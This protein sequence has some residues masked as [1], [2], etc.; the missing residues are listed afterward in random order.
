I[1]ARSVV[2]LLG[3]EQRI[4]PA[5]VVLAGEIG[6]VAGRNRL[7]IIA[8]QIRL[9]PGTAGGGQCLTGTA[10]GGVSIG[11]SGEAGAGRRRLLGEEGEHG[12]RILSRAYR[13]FCPKAELVLIRPARIGDQEPRIVS[14]GIAVALPETPPVTD[15]RG[16][17]GG[18]ISCR[19]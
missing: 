3:E 9:A 16:N 12:R 2:R 15:G 19:V 7:L 10:A 5:I 8:V 1:E 4:D 14:E 17:A 18:R 13:S 6:A 11:E